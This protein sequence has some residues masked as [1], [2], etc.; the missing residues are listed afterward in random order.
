[1]ESLNTPGKMLRCCWSLSIYDLDEQG[2]VPLHHPALCYTSEE[3]ER[4]SFNR[5]LIEGKLR[6]AFPSIVFGEKCLLAQ[7]AQ[8]I[9]E[10]A[11]EVNVVAR[12][13][14]RR[15]A[16]EGPIIPFIVQWA[17]EGMIRGSVA[18]HRII[19]SYPK[20]IHQKIE[21]TVE[22]MLRSFGVGEVSF[23]EY[24]DRDVPPSIQGE[25]W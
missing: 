21:Q 17:A 25:L 9:S 7:R 18:K 14:F 3:G 2:Q 19:I 15:T 5:K 16:Y 10:M 4:T 6:E 13:D 20:S 23:W 11:G 24:E 12:S 1:M 8:L 22:K